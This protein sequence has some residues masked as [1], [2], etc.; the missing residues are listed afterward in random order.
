MNGKWE[1]PTLF[2]RLF[3]G[4]GR[5]DVLVHRWTF[6]PSAVVLFLRSR[7]VISQAHPINAVV[8]EKSLPETCE[9]FT[10]VIPS[11][12]LQPYVLLGVWECSRGKGGG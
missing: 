11:K 7:Q 5:P 12:L 3:P 1:Q 2:I 10:E 8:R 9:L 4:D 6:W